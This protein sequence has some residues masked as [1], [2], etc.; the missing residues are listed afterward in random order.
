MNENAAFTKDNLVS[1]GELSPN[2]ADFDRILK[3][4]CGTGELSLELLNRFPT[5]LMRTVDRTAREESAIEQGG[6]LT[7]NSRSGW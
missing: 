5:T 4:A 7:E 6:T 2:L 1:P 3:L